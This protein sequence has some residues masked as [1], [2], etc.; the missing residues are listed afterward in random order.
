D[1]NPEIEICVWENIIKAFLK[2]DQ[3]RYLSDEQKKE[4]FILLFMRSMMSTSKVLE[5]W[6]LCKLPERAVK[7]I[8]RG[9]EAKPVMLVIGHFPI[10]R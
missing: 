8:L 7:E 1:E 9:Y 3:V 4:A 10:L 2:I 6:K 5:N